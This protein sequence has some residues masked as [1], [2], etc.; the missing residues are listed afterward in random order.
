MEGADLK[1]AAPVKASGLH[2][3]SKPV[4]NNA[5]PGRSCERTQGTA[6]TA[7]R[8][9]CD[10]QRI[11]FEDKPSAG[12]VVGGVGSEKI[13]PQIKY[14]SRRYREISWDTGLGSSV[15]VAQLSF[16]IASATR[17]KIP[18]LRPSIKGF[19]G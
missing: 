14:P 19:R 5:S 15:F 8:L 6:S 3:E 11:P 9:R 18:R 2:Q 13:D 1:S 4:G 12:L 16:V 7:A 17:T 10:G